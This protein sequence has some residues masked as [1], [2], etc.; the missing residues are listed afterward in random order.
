[1]SLAQWEAGYC[2]GVN[3]CFRKPHDHSI[4]RKFKDVGFIIALVCNA[5]EGVVISLSFWQRDTQYAYAWIVEIAL[6]CD[7]GA[8]IIA[9][10]CNS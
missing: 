5:Y 4:C 3:R 8:L 10:V 9:L 7:S 1:M 6:G 2:I